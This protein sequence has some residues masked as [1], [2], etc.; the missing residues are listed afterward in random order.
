MCKV[1]YCIAAF[2]VIILNSEVICYGQTND[3]GGQS[4]SPTRKE[5]R[6][7]IR[8]TERLVDSLFFASAKNAIEQRK[9]SLEVKTVY[10]KSGVLVQNDD[11]RNLLS[12]RGGSAHIRLS[13]Q[14]GI[15]GIS[16]VSVS[17]QVSDYSENIDKKG[18]VTVRYHVF[19]KGKNE[20]VFITLTG[21]GNLAN[22]EVES[23][24]TGKRIRFSGNLE[25]LEKIKS[26]GNKRPKK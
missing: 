18:I 4:K 2:I 12:M 9:W 22:V 25:P 17:G 1:L 16:S 15:K 13:F 10:D 20:E 14:K 23:S 3:V 21:N 11:P 24:L 7:M 8:N 19:N 6:V 5:K 26:S